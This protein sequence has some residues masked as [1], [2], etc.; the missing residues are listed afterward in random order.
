MIRATATY[1]KFTHAASVVNNSIGCL[2]SKPLIDMVVAIQDQVSIVVVKDL[3][4]I[5]AVEFGAASG[6]KQGNVPIGQ[7]AEIRVGIQICLEPLS[8][9]RRRTTSTCIPD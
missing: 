5:L 4:E 8:L 7:G 6:T 3:P 2:G 9:G 1:D